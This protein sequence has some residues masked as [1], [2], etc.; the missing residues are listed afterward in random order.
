MKKILFNYFKTS[1]IVSFL[2]FILIGCTEKRPI[3]IDFKE[4]R[5]TVKDLQKSYKKGYADGATESTFGYYTG[6]AQCIDDTL[7]YINNE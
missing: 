2:I 3:N 1:L 7:N 6:Y 5:Y 4:Y